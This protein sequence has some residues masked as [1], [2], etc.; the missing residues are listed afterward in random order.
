MQ[1]EV[2]TILANTVPSDCVTEHRQVQFILLIRGAVIYTDL[3]HALCALTN[4]PDGKDEIITAI[5]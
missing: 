4:V 5:S 2:G 1:K 3:Q